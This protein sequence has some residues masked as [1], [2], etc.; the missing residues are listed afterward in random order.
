LSVPHPFDVVLSYVP[1]FPTRRS[2]DLWG[3]PA[4][5][6]DGR[7]ASGPR[8]QSTR[9]LVWILASG[10]TGSLLLLRFRPTSRT[11][12]AAGGSADL[13]GDRKSTR[14]NSSH[15]KTSYAVFC[16]K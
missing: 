11:A 4:V 7:S 13:I 5:A 8:K 15:V 1:S 16:L 14:L 3:R 6:A 10:F 12:V 9:G 2:S